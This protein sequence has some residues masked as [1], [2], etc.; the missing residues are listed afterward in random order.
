MP[1]NMVVLFPSNLVYFIVGIFHLLMLNIIHSFSFLHLVPQYLEVI[2][3]TNDKNI[4]LMLIS[5]LYTK[6]KATR[7]YMMTERK[8]MSK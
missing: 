8:I 6:T 1:I 4:D 3:V 5:I 7:L 2:G